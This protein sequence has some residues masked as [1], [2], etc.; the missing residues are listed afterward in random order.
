[1]M[2]SVDVE[3]YI[4]QMVTFFENNPNDLMSLIGDVQKEEF[5]SK[6]KNKSLENVKNGDDFILTNK[7]KLYETGQKIAL[8]FDERELLQGYRDASQEV[9]EILLDLA[10]K[11]SRKKDFGPRS[12]RND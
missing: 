4:S 2:G 7:E 1:M 10:R 5:Y 9:R 11:A 6:M 8:T 12:E 3:I